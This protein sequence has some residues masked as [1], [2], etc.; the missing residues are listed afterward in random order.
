MN[1]RNV[2]RGK[3]QFKSGR[4]DHSRR[5]NRENLFSLFERR[6]VERFCE[7]KAYHVFFSGLSAVVARTSG[8]REVA[9]SILVAPTIRLILVLEII[10][11]FLRTGGTSQGVNA[12]SILV[13]PTTQ[14]EK[15]EKIYFLCLNDAEWKGFAK[16]KLTIC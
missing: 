10:R 5:K 7:A 6:R 12:S 14:G 11:L 1:W 9:S 16:Q 3:R 2:P 4:P 15:T 13:A 8:G